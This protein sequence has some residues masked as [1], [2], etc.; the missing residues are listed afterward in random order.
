MKLMYH[1]IK[2]IKM[3]IIIQFQLIIIKY[4]NQNFTI[5]LFLKIKKKSKTFKKV[6]YK[7]IKLNFVFIKNFIKKI[8]FHFIYN[9]NIIKVLPSK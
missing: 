5:L 4:N 3:K 1:I 2:K 9:N 8:N 6:I 7:V